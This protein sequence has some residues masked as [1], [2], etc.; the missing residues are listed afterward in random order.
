MCVID[1]LFQVKLTLYTAT[2][3]ERVL[4][5]KHSSIQT[6]F[7]NNMYVDM[8]KF[9]FVLVLGLHVSCSLPFTVILLA[10]HETQTQSCQAPQSCQY[11]LRIRREL[12]E[13]LQGLHCNQ[14]SAF[15]R[16]R[17]SQRDSSC[18]TCDIACVHLSAQHTV[19]TES[20]LCKHVPSYMIYIFTV[21]TVISHPNIDQTQS[22]NQ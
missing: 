3:S 2:L 9:V 14:G 17:D 19:H 6:D 22:W 7:P 21:H 15:L 13:V 12:S 4:Y 18:C 11:L 5:S 10:V 8:W 20:V 16:G 1:A